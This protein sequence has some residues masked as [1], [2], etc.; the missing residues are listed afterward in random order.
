MKKMSFQHLHYTLYIINY[1]LSHKAKF[2]FIWYSYYFSVDIDDIVFE[3]RTMD[4]ISILLCI[5]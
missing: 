4:S 1:S 5:I 3:Y 2:N